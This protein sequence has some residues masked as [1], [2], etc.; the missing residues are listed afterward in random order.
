MILKIDLV[1]SGGGY[2]VIIAI[3]LVITCALSQ[4]FDPRMLCDAMDATSG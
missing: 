4:Q 2:N 3:V 1:N